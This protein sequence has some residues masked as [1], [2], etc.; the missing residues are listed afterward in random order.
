MKL[1]K[2]L[3][4]GLIKK[5]S[6]KYILYTS[7]FL[8]IQTYAQEVKSTSGGDFKNSTTQVSFSIGEPLTQS[9]LNSTPKI[10]QG[11]HQTTISVSSIGLIQSEI[12]FSYYPIPTNQFI[13]IETL[14]IKGYII[15]FYNTLGQIILTD[16]LKSKTQF[17][18]SK[19][20]VGD[21]QVVI[22]DE[23]NTIHSKRTII[24]R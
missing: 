2:D 3:E 17:D 1:I 18:L 21:Y 12:K 22:Q 19:F 4:N 11:F 20:A 8:S 14:D 23:N 5:V 10:T 7:L 24:I 6:M 13:T 15:N 9:Y 16:K